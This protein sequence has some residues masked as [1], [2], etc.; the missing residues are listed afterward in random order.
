MADLPELSDTIYD[1]YRTYLFKYH[2][3]LERLKELETIKTEN[4]KLKTDNL[5]L[6]R[7]LREMEMDKKAAHFAAQTESRMLREELRKMMKKPRAK[8]SRKSLTSDTP[9]SLPRSGFFKIPHI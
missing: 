4:E 9:I 8:K 3:G 7:Q 2:E 5:T 1:E 6:K